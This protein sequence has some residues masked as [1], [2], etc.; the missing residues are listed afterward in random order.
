VKP[1]HRSPLLRHFVLATTSLLGFASLANAGI[2]ILRKITD[3]LRNTPL[4]S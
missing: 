3:F 2:F 4:P 1:T